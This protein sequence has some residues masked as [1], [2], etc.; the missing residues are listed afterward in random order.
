M[1]YS[2]VDKKGNSY[3]VGT[4]TGTITIDTMKRTA[5]GQDVYVTK[6]SNSG[7]IEW[8][9]TFGG[10][11]FQEAAQVSPDHD[12]NVYVT[13]AFLNK[14]EVGDST[15]TSAGSYDAFLAKIDKMARYYG[16]K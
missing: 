2:T 14:L 8:V 1:R 9:T 3:L 15:Y 10:A 11:N 12:G 13:G 6:V 5:S 16:V 7:K 4:F